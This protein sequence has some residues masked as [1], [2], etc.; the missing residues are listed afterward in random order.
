MRLPTKPKQFPTTTHTFRMGLVIFA[1][2]A[3]ASGAVC[4]PLT[5]STIQAA[6]FPKGPVRLIINIINYQCQH[7][8]CLRLA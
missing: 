1:T 6:L 8:M 7:E 3:T 4:A 5:S 2:A